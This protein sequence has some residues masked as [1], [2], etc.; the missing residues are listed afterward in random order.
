MA[1]VRYKEISAEMEKLA[2][3][4]SHWAGRQSI[5]S[6][7]DVGEYYYIDVDR[8][9]P[10]NDQARR[11]F[12]EDEI[13]G[14]AKTISEY[15]V[16]QPLSIIKTENGAYQVVSGE[17]RLRAAKRAGLSKVPCIMVDKEK[18]REIALVEN[19]QRSDLHPVE[20]GDAFSKLLNYAERGSVRE[21]AV[22]L[23]KSASTISE[24]SRLAALP[25]E[26]KNHL[27]DHNIRTKN[28]LRRL[29]YAKDSQ[30]MCEILGLGEHKGMSAKKAV[31]LSVDPDGFF[32]EYNRIHK[33]L[34]S[35][36]EALKEKLQEVINYL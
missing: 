20:L 3:P 6:E 31:L 29:L 1:K 25:D 17:R 36:K 16:R 30:E 21:L 27:I 23:G 33:L 28:I 22:R 15:G 34:P 24:Y 26:I 9:E 11:I 7:D 8:I 14:L 19:I 18:A 4:T 32:V 13:N 35:Q 2:A 12:D 5:G 10:Y